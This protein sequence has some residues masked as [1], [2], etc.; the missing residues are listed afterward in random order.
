VPDISPLSQLIRRLD[1][2]TD[3]APVTDTIPTGFPSIDQMLG[4][5][6]R[7]G[8]LVVLGG[9][10]GSGKSALA[11]AITIRAALAGT[12]ATYYTGEMTED[13]VLERMLAL[14]GRIRVDDLRRGVLDDATR[15]ALGAAAVRFRDLSPIVERLPASVDALRDAVRDAV[16]ARPGLRLAV[17]DAL[18]SLATG[19]RATQD[20]ELALV[21]RALKTLA[22]E[23]GVAVVLVAHLPFF[24][25]DRHDRRPTL[26]DFGARHAIKQHADIVLGLFREEMYESAQ[27]VEGATE[28]LTLKN[29][30][31]ATG[32]VDLYFYKQWLRFEDLLER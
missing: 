1:A 26:D 19:Q 31:G 10:V 8:D 12:A 4:G 29:R 24:R 2:R 18:Q 15:A 23:Q 28:L 16:H 14:E 30:N 21:V 5:G 9:D 13:R 25:H 17:I 20:E 3:G 27:N 32:Y 7:T 6:V 22:V 11:L